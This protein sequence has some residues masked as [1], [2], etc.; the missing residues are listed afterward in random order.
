[1]AELVTRY[2]VDMLRRELETQ[3]DVLR[4]RDLLRRGDG[5]PRK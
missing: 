5:E 2:D 3:I 4:P 1:M